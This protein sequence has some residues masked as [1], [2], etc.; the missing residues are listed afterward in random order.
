MLVTW[1]F[2][3]VVINS[4]DDWFCELTVH[5]LQLDVYC[6]EHSFSPSPVY[7]CRYVWVCVRTRYSL[8]WSEPKL[9]WHDF[10]AWSEWLLCSTV[11]YIEERTNG[12]KVGGMLKTR[13]DTLLFPV[14]NVLKPYFFAINFL[15]L[16]FSLLPLYGIAVFYLHDNLSTWSWDSHSDFSPL[17]L[18]Y[19]KQK[20]TH[21]FFS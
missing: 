13:V 12:R 14:S 6:D 7:V 16:S 4:L 11:D 1:I 8:K 19:N 15:I 20:L 3:Y 9:G 17:I 10:C 2:F 21:Q 18:G 5:I